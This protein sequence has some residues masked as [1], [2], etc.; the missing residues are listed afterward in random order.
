MNVTVMSRDVATRYC[1][2]NHNNPVVMISVSD[3]YL[4]YPNGPFCSERN[5]VLAIQPLFFT[6]ADKPGKD[7]YDREVTENDLIN[8]ADAQLIKRLL[9]LHPDTDVIVHCDAGISRYCFINTIPCNEKLMRRLDE[10]RMNRKFE[11]EI[12]VDEN[13]NIFDGYTSYLVYRMLGITNVPVVIWPKDM[14]K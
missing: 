4:T 14:R 11:T 1:Y 13:L 9:S 3:P 7:V 6:D 12:F 5:K 2:K 8:E 10:W